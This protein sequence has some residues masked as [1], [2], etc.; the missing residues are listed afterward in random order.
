MIKVLRIKLFDFINIYR[1]LHQF[2]NKKFNYYSDFNESLFKYLINRQCYYL[3]KDESLV[4]IFLINTLSRQIHY[5]PVVQKDISLFRL[6]Y[7]LNTNFN[8]SGY[9]LSI[10]HK[11]LN[12]NLYRKYFSVHIFDNYKYMSLETNKIPYNTTS[13]K[14][15]L[16][17]RKMVINKEEP[18]RVMLQNDIFSNSVGRRELT[19]IE[20]YNE[21]SSSSFLR[22]MCFILDIEGNP[23]GYG[24]I[25]LTD[26]E[27]YLVNFGII[28]EYRTRGYG[29][30]F[31]SQIIQNCSLNGVE[32][33]HLCVD[34]NNLPAVQLYKKL[35]FKESYNKFS[36]KFR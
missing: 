31:L 28:H 32:Y 21:E 18:L 1:I 10:N 3:L 17:F 25:L 30:Y 36:I 9:S 24:Q 22:D 5:I 19:I 11:N 26:G 34:N 6:I 14:D 2:N 27:Y 35:G 23:G 7:S 29:E 16:L 20:V 13:N 4:G 33:L 8:L 12:P 15:N